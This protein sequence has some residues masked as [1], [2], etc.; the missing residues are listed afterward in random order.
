MKYCNQLLSLSVLSLYE[1]ELIGKVDKLYFDKKLKRLTKIEIIGENDARFLLDT[2]NI[3]H[4]GK[5]AI[6]VKNNQCLSFKVE[7]VGLNLAPINSKVYSINGEYLGLV[8]EIDLDDKFFTQKF[9]LDNNSVL[10]ISD[11]ASCGKNTIIFFDKTNKINLQKFT[12]TKSPKQFKNISIESVDIMPV[13]S[14][15]ENVEP[16]DNSPQKPIINNSDFL[17]GRI[18]YKDIFNFNNE[19][20][21]KAHSTINKKNLKEITRFGKLRE[22]I[23]FSR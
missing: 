2:K 3:Y 18:C 16:V 15:N 22:L 20:L 6:T 11:L 12:P 10:D 4:I 19:L 7:E 23:M 13:E 1:G 9:S 14:T 8:K 21:I 5:N 17:L